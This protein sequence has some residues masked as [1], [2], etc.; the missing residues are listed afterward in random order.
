MKPSMK[1]HI[2]GKG[3]EVEGALKQRTGQLND[4]PALA[5]EGAV[6]KLRGHARQVLGKIEKAV[7][8]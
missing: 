3:E 6:E 2:A 8:S 7:G 1:D 4:D 5:E